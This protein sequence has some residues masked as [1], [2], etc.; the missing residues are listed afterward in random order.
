MILSI[1]LK[2]T[3]YIVGC[4][5][6][7]AQTTY[8]VGNGPFSVKVVDVNSDSKPD[9]IVTNADSNNVGV[10]FSKGN[11]SFAPQVTYTVGSSPY[12][13]EVVDG[14]GDNKLDIVVANY[15][16]DSVGVLMH[17]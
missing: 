6:F 8:P 10:L 14:N 9:I 12:W 7:N 11:G 5:T 17:C 3:L 16:S 2:N 15:G 13:V 1:A 4:S